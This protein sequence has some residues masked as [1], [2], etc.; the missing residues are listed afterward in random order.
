MRHSARRMLVLALA[1]APLAIA[2]PMVWSTSFADFNDFAV[3]NPQVVCSL[4]NAP[5]TGSAA[6]PGT[7]MTMLFDAYG[8]ANYGMLQAYGSAL[9]SGPSG[10]TPPDYAVVRGRG[11]YRDIF[12]VLG[13]PAGSDGSMSLE[14]TVT[15]TSMTSSS[16]NLAAS[17][18]ILRLSQSGG[19]Y[20]D[21]VFESGIDGVAVSA[22]IPIV[23]GQPFE[24]EVWFTGG[25]NILDF[26]N[27]SYAN[28]DFYHTA[29]LTG[30][31]V[32][33]ANQNL[34]GDFQIQADSGT[35]YTAHG[36]VPEPSTFLLIGATVPFLLL[37][38]RRRV[39]Q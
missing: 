21:D 15:G 4:T 25:I 34:I 31:G 20:T 22:A 38:L 27:G 26:S 37:L 28:A 36:I 35:V 16:T 39:R 19:G 3:F 17:G 29:I 14:F 33:D 2:T 7:A 6:V 8:A 12:T 11:A 10:G 9:I 23:F 30:I 18:F 5:C 32:L 13:G 24:Y 1:L